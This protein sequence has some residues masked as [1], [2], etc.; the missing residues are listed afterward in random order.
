MIKNNKFIVHDDTDLREGIKEWFCNFQK[1]PKE[2]AFIEFRIEENAKIERYSANGFNNLLIVI[3]SL[4][5][6]NPSIRIYIQLIS[7][8]ILEKIEDDNQTILRNGIK[9]LL[10][11]LNH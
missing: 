1:D 4:K 5:K 9:N 10:I 3:C 11:F 6:Q 2:I 8:E 7:K